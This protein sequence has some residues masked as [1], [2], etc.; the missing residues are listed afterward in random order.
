MAKKLNTTGSLWQDSDGN[1]YSYNTQITGEYK[2]LRVF[3]NTFYSMTTRKHQGQFNKHYFELIL[4]TCRFSTRLQP[5][6][7]EQ[8][9]KYELDYIDDCLKEL[10]KKRNTKKKKDTIQQL[11]NRKEFLVNVLNK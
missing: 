5:D 7:I 11:N 2:G 3:N 6:E 4:T 10:D 9:I 1:A 8:A